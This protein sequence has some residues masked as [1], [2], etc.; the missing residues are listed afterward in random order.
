MNRWNIP[1][2]LEREVIERDRRCVYC[3]VRFAAQSTSR[4]DRPSWEHIINDARIVTPGNI[5]RCCIGCNASKGTKSLVGWLDSKYCMTRGITRESVASIV[6]AAL[7]AR[8]GLH[9][10]RL[11]CG[12]TGARGG[13]RCRSSHLPFGPRGSKGEVRP[14]PLKVAKLPFEMIVIDPRSRRE[15]RLK[16]S[17]RGVEGSSRS[18]N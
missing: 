11:P 18:L 12:A 1:E 14:M 7:E 6:R 17:A 13:R 5:A 2:W 9:V 15:S 4:R 8:S 16:D 3:G 10:V